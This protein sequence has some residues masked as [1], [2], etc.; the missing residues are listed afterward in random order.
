MILALAVLTE[1]L[2]AAS[3]EVDGGGVEEH[4]VQPAEQILPP[5]E[6]GLLDQVLGAACGEGSGPEL[7]IVG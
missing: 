5:G 7:L 1:G 6:Q 3:L 2:A 4:Q